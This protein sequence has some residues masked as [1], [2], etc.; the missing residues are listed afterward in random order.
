MLLLVSLVNN[1]LIWKTI[2][3][4]N[5]HPTSLNSAINYQNNLLK[6]ACEVDIY[7]GGFG[8]LYIATNRNSQSNIIIKPS[9]YVSQNWNA[10]ATVSFN[11]AKGKIELIMLSKGSSDSFTDFTIQYV[12]YR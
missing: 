1:N 6:G 2:T 9:Y 8:H 10:C 7:I 11:S 12:G 4:I 5:K 3:N